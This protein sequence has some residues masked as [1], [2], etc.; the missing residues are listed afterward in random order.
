[1][2]NII[3]NFSGKYA[4]LSNFYPRSIRFEGI[5]FPLLNMRIKLQ[6]L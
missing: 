4:F 2:K 5:I 1:M 3:N 6:K